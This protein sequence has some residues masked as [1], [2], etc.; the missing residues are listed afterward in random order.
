MPILSNLSHRFH[1]LTTDAKP[2]PPRIPVEGYTHNLES[3]TVND[4]EP[5][6]TKFESVSIT[7]EAQL[8]QN[9]TSSEKNNAAPIT[10]TKSSTK[11]QDLNDTK[12]SSQNANERKIP[13]VKTKTK[14][15]Q[16]KHS[17][18][19]RTRVVNYNIIN[20][21]GVKIGSRTSY[22]CNINQFANGHVK[23]TEELC[24][25]KIRQMPAEVERLCVCTDE[26]TLDDI[27]T[28]KTYIGH[29]WRDVARK[30]LYSEGQI[31]QFEENYKFRGISEVIYQLFLDW[32][33]ANTKNANIGNLINILWICKEYDCAI[34]LASARNI[35]L[36]YH[37]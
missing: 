33:R 16:H 31:E 26:I 32:K 13:N 11:E 24:S 25:K 15:K 28:I 7:S 19:E 27:F 6:T 2:D 5:K 1:M 21:N 12:A 3:N 36:K 37:K 22:I 23:A 30:L 10:N 34:L 14:S 8:E 17:Q 4:D 20:S 9:V 29:G 18:G 35:N